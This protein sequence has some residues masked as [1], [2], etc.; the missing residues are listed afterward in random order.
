[1]TRISVLF[2]LLAASAAQAAPVVTFQWDSYPVDSTHNTGANKFVI[3]TKIDTKAWVA[4]PDI[5]PITAISTTIDLAGRTG[6][7][8]TG[9]LKAC[10][11]GTFANPPTTADDCS[12]WSNEASKN[13]APPEA[14]T[15]LKL[16]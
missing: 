8:V 13:I 10:R 1:M 4:A 7:T 15:G 16:Q 6:T 2:A 9:R 11:P 14:P 3:E 5:T 12:A